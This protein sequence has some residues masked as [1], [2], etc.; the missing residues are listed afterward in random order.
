MPDFT[1]NQKV[2]KIHNARLENYFEFEYKEN[3]I[4]TKASK[5]SKRGKKEYIPLVSSEPLPRFGKHFW[6]IRILWSGNYHICMG[7]VDMPSEIKLG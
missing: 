7:I 4:I 2:F 6:S 3:Q 5:T 1:P